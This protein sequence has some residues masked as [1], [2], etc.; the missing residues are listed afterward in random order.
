MGKCSIPMIN[1]FKSQCK[2]W[3]SQLKL[4]TKDPKNMV[5]NFSVDYNFIEWLKM[6]ETCVNF[7]LKKTVNCGQVGHVA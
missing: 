4:L 6:K 7:D 5:L 2:T 3:M 1:N